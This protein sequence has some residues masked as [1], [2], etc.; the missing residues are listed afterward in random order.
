MGVSLTEG[1]EGLN[2]RTLPA[3]AAKRESSLSLARLLPVASL[4]SFSEC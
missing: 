2:V 3:L 4:R 1:S